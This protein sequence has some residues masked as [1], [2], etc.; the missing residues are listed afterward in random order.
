LGITEET[1]FVPHGWFLGEV[2]YRTATVRMLTGEDEEFLRELSPSFL[3]VERSTAILCRCV[4]A[5]AGRQEVTPEA[6]CDL[7]VGDREALLFHIRRI[8]E[9]DRVPLSIHC[10][11]PT[12]KEPMDLD[13]MLSELLQPKATTPR[14]VY[15]ETVECKGRKI[16]ARFRL[17]TGGD[18]TAAARSAT[19]APKTAA[20]LL[21][22]RCVIDLVDER[23]DHAT[24]SEDVVDAVE[25]EMARLDPQAETILNLTCP[26]CGHGFSAS[27]DA[28][29]HLFSDFADRQE[30]LY[31]EVHLIALH[32]HWSEREILSMTT[33][34]RRLYLDLLRNGLGE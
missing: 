7:T 24:V 31:R 30:T 17:P 3:P 21:F 33:K 8:S 2:H 23:G 28:G 29:L 27:F 15:S 16:T 20:V 1:V 12:C 4:T 13:L 11:R 25:I 32:Y 5:L 18:Q 26:V 9:G 22:E 19:T 14:D 6:L 10:P 34:K